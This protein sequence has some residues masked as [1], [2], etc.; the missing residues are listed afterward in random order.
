SLTAPNSRSTASPSLPPN[1]PVFLRDVQ[2][3]CERYARCH[4]WSGILLSLRLN[5]KAHRD[6]QWCQEMARMRCQRL[7]LWFGS[8]RIG[9]GVRWSQGQFAYFET[10]RFQG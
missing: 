1:S 7:R 4:V 10:F 6:S 2:G 5:N 3:L 9:W 8:I